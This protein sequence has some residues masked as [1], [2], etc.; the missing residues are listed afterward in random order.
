[1]EYTR[2]LLTLQ[3]QIDVLKQWGLLIEDEAEAI[4]VLD[5]IS[6]FRLAGYWRLKERDWQSHIFKPNSCFS[7]IISLY[8]FDEE[9]R[10]LVFSA[11]QQIEV[12]VRS[13]L[14][15]LFSERY[16]A[17]WFMQPALAENGNL[18]A[19]NIRSLQEELNR[20]EDEYSAVSLT[21]ILP[22]VLIMSSRM[23]II[24]IFC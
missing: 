13:R 1:M 22:S 2:Q 4:A 19:S 18:F 9:L 7:K 6:Y 14:I 15:R 17:F 21:S 8:R 11:I 5:A 3:Q 12:T 20:S 10:L 16:G 23:R 24:A